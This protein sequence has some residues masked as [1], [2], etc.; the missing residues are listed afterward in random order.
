MKIGEDELTGRKVMDESGSLI[1]VVSGSIKDKTTR[2]RQTR[3]H[4]NTCYLPYFFL[5]D[6]KTLYWKIP[7][8]IILI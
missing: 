6:L 3:T 4:C 5:I 1:G 2:S 8:I 7:P